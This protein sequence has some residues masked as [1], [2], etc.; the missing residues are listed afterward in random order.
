MR[1]INIKIVCKVATDI[2]SIY[3]ILPK[4]FEN[5]CRCRTVFHNPMRINLTVNDWLGMS[6][7]WLSKQYLQCKTNCYLWLCNVFPHPG[8]HENLLICFCVSSDVSTAL[9]TILLPISISPNIW[10]T[11][12]PQFVLLLMFTAVLF[13]SLTPH[14]LFREYWLSC[15]LCYIDKSLKHFCLDTITCIINVVTSF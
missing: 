2:N 5:Q 10:M 6:C 7:A 15:L 9:Q 11:D 4:L 8:F 13:Y 12:A 1:L 3:Q 14:Y